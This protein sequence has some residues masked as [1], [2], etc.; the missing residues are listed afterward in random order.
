MPPVSSKATVLKTVL[1][2]QT[3]LSITYLY[4]FSL[5]GAAWPQEG[6]KSPA[7]R[8]TTQGQK[9][10]RRSLPGPITRLTEST[11]EEEHSN[12]FSSAIRFTASDM[13]FSTSKS[14]QAVE[15]GIR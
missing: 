13:I 11:L 4:N 12:H 1:K 5:W 15:A 7:Q 14:G 2:W 6:Q 9:P 8:N 10:T 3:V